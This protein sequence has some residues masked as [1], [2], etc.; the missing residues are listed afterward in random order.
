[1]CVCVCLNV[2]ENPTWL[3]YDLVQND[4]HYCCFDLLTLT[5]RRDKFRPR[6]SA[7]DRKVMVEMVKPQ[8]FYH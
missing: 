1:M 7:N 3:L 2:S 6:V 5:T 8:I 4:K